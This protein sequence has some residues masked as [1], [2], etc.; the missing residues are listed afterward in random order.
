MVHITADKKTVVYKCLHDVGWIHNK[1][2]KTL[3][4]KKILH[5]FEIRKKIKL[6]IIYLHVFN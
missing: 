5:I 6:Y 4:M 3:E 1:L 2:I